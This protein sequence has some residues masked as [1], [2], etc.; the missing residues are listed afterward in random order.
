MVKLANGVFA[1]PVRLRSALRINEPE[2]PMTRMPEFAA[3]ES[4]RTS[5]V[6]LNVPPL[7]SQRLAFKFPV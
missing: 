2:L 4:G 6:T 7:I 1:V 3:P 5:P